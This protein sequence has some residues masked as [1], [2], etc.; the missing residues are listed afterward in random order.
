M[1]FFFDSR[2]V[3]RRVA[4]A[5]VLSLFLLVVAGCGR[6]Y[7]PVTEELATATVVGQ[8][9]LSD[10]GENGHA[11]IMVFLGGTSFS[12]RTSENGHYAIGGIPVGTYTVM[13]ERSD[14][15]TVNVGQAAVSPASHNA[16]SPFTMPI[17][18][19]ERVDD[20]STS[21]LAN[22]GSIAG[23]VAVFE[24]ETGAGVR[25]SI[26]GAEFVTVTDEAGFYYLA[27]VEAGRYVLSFE[28]EGYPKAQTTVKVEGGKQA[29]AE[30]VVLRPL[31][32][33]RPTLR[34]AVAAA[35]ADPTAP[36]MERESLKGDRSIVGIVQAR[37]ADGLVIND[38]TRIDVSIDNS[39]YVVQPDPSGRFVFANLPAGVYTVIVILDGAGPVTRRVDLTDETRVTLNIEIGGPEAAGNGG[40]EGRVVLEVPEGQGQP[41]AAGASVGLGGTRFTA[42]ADGGGEFNLS[43]VPPGTYEIIVSAEGFNTL[44]V[45]DVVVAAGETTDLGDIVVSADVDY[46]RVVG[47]WPAEGTKGV[48]AAEQVLLKVKFNKPMNTDT[49]RRAVSITPSSKATTYMGPGSHPE[50][51]EFTLV[52]ALDNMDPSQP[53]RFKQDYELR[54]AASA[55]D[56]DGIK[57]QSDFS[58]TFQTGA[59]GI[60]STLPANGQT[61][62]APVLPDNVIEIRFNTRIREETLDARSIRIRPRS[63]TI[64]QI[65]PVVDP[66]TGWTTLYVTVPLAHDT[67]YSV[68]VGR[69]VRSASGQALSNTPY[70]F[71]FR[72]DRVRQVQAEPRVHF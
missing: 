54:I 44:R 14:Y 49:V 35:P 61:I 42:L 25:V 62:V 11:G 4:A 64:P 60:V 18:I 67:R 7:Q 55:S 51:D 23:A 59:P 10:G 69:T 72:T 37:D 41:S 63:D 6:N 71:T 3:M 20:S 28:K 39:D 45:P 26:E 38:F 22:L 58:L 43:E 50:A 70:D 30:E 9:L 33:A 16:L 24:A 5:A 27:N 17:A 68:S 47:T 57:M 29:A 2:N 46:P 31:V 52:I 12:A 1:M 15:R 48:T 21:T 65:R 13:A 40:V 53:I 56:R 36:M 32:A 19:L 8:A 66:R 34:P